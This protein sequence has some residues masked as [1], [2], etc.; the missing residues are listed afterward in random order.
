MATG[1]IGARGTKVGDVLK[2]EYKAYTGYTREDAVVTVTADMEVG[3][4]LE[5]TSVAGKYTLTTVATGGN[6]D[7]VLI[8]SE[9]YNI[10]PATVFPADFTLAVLVDGPAQVSKEALSFGADV[11]TQPEIDTVV[12]A[13]EANT[14]IKAKQRV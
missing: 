11:D 4:V 6:A 13:L 9:V 2:D 10:D 3:A 1:L 14:R 8:D 5:S 7:G 12:A